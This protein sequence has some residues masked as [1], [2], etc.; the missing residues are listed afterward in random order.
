MARKTREKQ[1]VNMVGDLEFIHVGELLLSPRFKVSPSRPPLLSLA[2]EPLREHQMISRLY[3]VNS[4]QP[5][6]SSPN[7]YVT[8]V[9]RILRNNVNIALEEIMHRHSSA[10]VVDHAMKVLIIHIDYQGLQFATKVTIGSD[11]S[12]AS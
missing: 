2:C 1:E 7:F 4:Q 3:V 6:R 10:L 12:T 11:L 5:S 8:R 9:D